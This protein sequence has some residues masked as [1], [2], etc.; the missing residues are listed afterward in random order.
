MKNSTLL[1]MADGADGNGVIAQVQGDKGAPSGTLSLG[2]DGDDASGDTGGDNEPVAAD[3][4]TQ[5]KIDTKT[6]TK[7]KAAKVAPV[8][9][10]E[11]VG[12][13]DD[14]L[15]GRV[16]KEEKEDIKVETKVDDKTKQQDAIAQSKARDYSIFDSTPEL[17]TVVEKYRNKV[18]NEVFDTLV[19]VAKDATTAKTQYKELETKYTEASKGIVKLP[20]S[21]IEHPAA[22]QFNPEVKQLRSNIT[23][24]EAQ[25][26]HYLTQKD[27]I[28][29]G[30][31][32]EDLEGVNE[33]GTFKT[34]LVEA[35]NTTSAHKHAIDK[36]IRENENS[37]SQFSAKLNGLRSSHVQAHK[38]L[39]EGIDTKMKEF[40]PWL[41]DDK[42]LDSPL[43]TVDDK[44]ELKE[45]TIKAHMEHI[46]NMLP[47]FIR[48]S[49]AAT[50]II[51]QSVGLALV[52]AKLMVYENKETINTQVKQDI[53]AAEPKVGGGKAGSGK[54]KD[55]GKIGNMDDMY[56][57]D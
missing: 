45:V 46:R 26:Q 27:R 7:Q 56:E 20:D 11:I 41:R 23:L 12:D 22:W 17:K 2:S 14:M 10:D 47:P 36:I 19:K 1:R 33:D 8:Y 3:V 48:N 21:Y 9:G 38:Q 40:C 18:P 5:P 53:T 55:D 57:K 43:L 35:K 52:Q 50:I 37:A 29:A 44:G 16:Y 34:S 13:M 42:L 49:P 51:N 30:E 39:V 4:S 24:A 54:A 31:D 28:E 25:V 6:T 15:E 32:W